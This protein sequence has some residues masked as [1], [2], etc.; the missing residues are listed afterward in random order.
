MNIGTGAYLLMGLSMMNDMTE[1]QERW[2]Q[3]IRDEWEKSKNY[4]RK[5][6]KRVRK[7][8][9]LDWAFANWSPFGDYKI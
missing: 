1:G 6:K 7:E 8:L 2:K 4:P 9:L 3:R 5:K